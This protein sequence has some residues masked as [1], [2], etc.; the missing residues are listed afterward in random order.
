MVKATGATGG[1]DAS[2]PALGR[3]SAGSFL[4]AVQVGAK[5]ASPGRFEAFGDSEFLLITVESEE[6]FRAESKR[7][8]DVQH[9]E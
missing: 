6:C 1:I 7:A 3:R 2:D 5:L 9:I 4:R 8:S